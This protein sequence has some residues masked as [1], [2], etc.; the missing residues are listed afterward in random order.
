MEERL[1]ELESKADPRPRAG[2]AEDIQSLIEA[3][4]GNQTEQEEAAWQT[5]LNREFAGLHDL[6]FMG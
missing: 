2:S 4:D 1:T 3:L 5:Q 6:S